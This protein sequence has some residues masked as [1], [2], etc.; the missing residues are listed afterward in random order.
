MLGCG[1]GSGKRSCPSQISAFGTVQAPVLRVGRPAAAGAC[2]AW[3]QG[4]AVCASLHSLRA[5][6]GVQPPGL[7][8]AEAAALPRRTGSGASCSTTAAPRRRRSSSAT[9]RG[10]ST[11]TAGGVHVMQHGERRAV[12]ITAAPRRRRSSTTAGR[13]TTAA[14]Q[15]A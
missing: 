10:R 1:P 4:T 7:K 12:V 11:G 2:E 3:L 14:G 5:L 8:P 9:R 13:G 6:L 15:L